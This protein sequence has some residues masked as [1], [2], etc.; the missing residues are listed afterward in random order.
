M[1]GMKAATKQHG[2]SVILLRRDLP[3]PKSLDYTR[4]EITGK[5]SKRKYR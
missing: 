1:N 4:K 2:S 5:S 3:R